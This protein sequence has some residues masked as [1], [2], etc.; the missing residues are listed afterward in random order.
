MLNEAQASEFVRAVLTTAALPAA[1]TALAWGVVRLVSLRAG[2]L[3]AAALPMGV[4]VGVVAADLGVLGLR[5]G[6]WPTDAKERLVYAF[7]LAGV[8][9]GVFAALSRRRSL[10]G[11]SA[12]A[13]G[14]RA[15]RRWRR[16]LLGLGWRAA[17][18]LAAAWVLS[19][20]RRSFAWGGWEASA[21]LAAVTVAAAWHWWSWGVAPV[22]S[23]L[24][25]VTPMVA[26]GVFAGGSSA[27]V[28]F[29]GAT[30][31]GQAIAAMG[32]AV[33]A[34]VVVAAL[35]RRGVGESGS[36]GA[37]VAV[38]SVVLMA[39][40]ATSWMYAEMP[41][42]TAALLS[43]APLGVWLPMAPVV[44]RA[45]VWVKRVAVVGFVAVAVGAAAALPGASYF[46]GADDP[47][48]EY[49]Y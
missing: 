35:D 13:E 38:A 6:W 32:S 45:G 37:S 15:R 10:R 2:W 46:G 27:A 19:E 29:S 41:T 34:G 49:G 30:S 40:S 42:A 23:G 33:G 44:R 48:A 26:A 11:S 17:L 7:A 21:V 43:A 8:L 14:D 4:S 3:A 31:L 18:V 25:R 39:S 9:T 16:A 20:P 12:G 24:G 1:S 5:D 47:Y 22:R 36:A 28:V